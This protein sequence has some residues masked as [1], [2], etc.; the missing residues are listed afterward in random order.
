LSNAAEK[1]KTELE[2]LN[3]L[4]LFYRNSLSFTVAAEFRG[5]YALNTGNAI[6]E[7]SG[8]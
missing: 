4:W 7:L 3:Y 8:L 2:F 5:I 1:Y 6:A